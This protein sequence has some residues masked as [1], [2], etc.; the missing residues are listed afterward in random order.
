MEALLTI[1]KE[2]LNKYFSLYGKSRLPIVL[3]KDGKQEV[4]LVY[5][6]EDE[7]CLKFLKYRNKDYNYSLQDL[8]DLEYILDARLEYYNL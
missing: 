4:I 1:I 5:L 3:R 2:K 8:K 7:L 6:Q